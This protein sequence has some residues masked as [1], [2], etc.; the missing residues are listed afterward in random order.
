M[1]IQYV[2]LVTAKMLLHEA[3][4]WNVLPRIIIKWTGCEGHIYFMQIQIYLGIQG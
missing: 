4:M 3:G 1:L 2:L